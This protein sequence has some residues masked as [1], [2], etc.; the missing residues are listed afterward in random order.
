MRKVAIRPPYLTRFT[1]TPTGGMPMVRHNL[2]TKNFRGMK[3]A[4]DIDRRFETL[5]RSNRVLNEAQDPKRI[6]DSAQ[7]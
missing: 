7:V 2:E 4:A 3:N 5:A 6:D 1:A